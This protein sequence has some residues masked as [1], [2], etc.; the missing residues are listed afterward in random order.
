MVGRTVLYVNLILAAL[1]MSCQPD[2]L[3][4]AATDIPFERIVLEN[5]VALH[6]NI[7]DIN[8]DGKNDIIIAADYWDD[9][10]GRDRTKLKVV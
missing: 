3:T 2:K 4:V 1:A 9:T 7:G 6:P 5:T 8:D 10:S